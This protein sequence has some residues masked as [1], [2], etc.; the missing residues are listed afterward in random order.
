MRQVISKRGER[1]STMAELT[2]VAIVFFMLII[3]IIEFGRL[4]YTHNALTDATRRGARYAVLHNSAS[5][6]CVAKVVVYGEAHVDPNT[7]D[8]VSGAQPLINGLIEAK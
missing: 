8:P 3:G 1:G 4:L 5:T 7:C 2:I 6:A